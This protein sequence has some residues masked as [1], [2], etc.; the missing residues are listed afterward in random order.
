MSSSNALKA[1]W[2]QEKQAIATIRELKEQIEQLKL[3]EQDAS[4]RATTNAPRRSSTAN[5]RSSKPS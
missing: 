3:E 2:K 4:A 1:R 5:F